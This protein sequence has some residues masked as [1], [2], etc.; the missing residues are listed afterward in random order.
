MWYYI[1]MVVA[2][3]RKVSCGLRQA[4]WLCPGAARKR[5]LQLPQDTEKDKT[6][7]IGKYGF[8]VVCAALV[9]TGCSP[10]EVEL[11]IP[12]SAIQ[13][14]RTGSSGEATATVVFDSEISDI[15]SKLPKIREIVTPYLGKDGKLTTRGSRITAKFN[16]PVVSSSFKGA[17]PE[18][19]L[20]RLVLNEDNTL[21]FKPTRQMDALSKS[22]Q[23]I[24]FTLDVDFKAKHFIFRFS[25]DDASSLKLKATAVFVD[26]KAYV[27][28]E[29]KITDGDSVDI[30][31]RCDSNASIYNQIDPFVT[32]EVVK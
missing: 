10:E 4:V 27:A 6:M 9:L 13:K 29:K 17:S 31:F 11:D 15:K 25:G 21:Q 23:S 30:E 28:Y 24:D 1:H 8:L 3:L 14:A 19:P 32:V 20:A 12:T 2:P 16:V 5:G 22:L 7:K 26:E 18:M